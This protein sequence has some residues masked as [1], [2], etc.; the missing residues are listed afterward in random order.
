MIIKIDAEPHSS[1]TGKAA[2]LLPKLRTA[3]EAPARVV[4][5]VRPVRV[6]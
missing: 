5:R 1:E 4:D 2:A 6:A 3:Q